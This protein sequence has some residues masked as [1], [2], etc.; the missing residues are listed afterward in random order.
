MM[1][2]DWKNGLKKVNWKKGLQTAGGV[3]R[4]VGGAFKDAKLENPI[5]SVGV[6]LFV[7]IFCGILVCVVTLGW[8]SYSQSRTIIKTKVADSNSQTAEQIAGRLN[9][10]LTSYEQKTMEFLSDTSFM[11]TL[12]KAVSPNV[13]EFER[14][15]AQRDVSEK[16]S[17]IIFADKNINGVYLLPSQ[18]N[19]TLQPIGTASSGSMPD[20]SVIKDMPFMKQMLDAQGKA[21]WAPT[22]EKGL[23]GS[24]PTP[25]IAVGRALVNLSNGSNQY[26]IVIELN[27]TFLKDLVDQFRTGDGSTSR[28][29]APDGTIVYSSIAKENGTK[30][31]NPLPK[32]GQGITVKEN[33]KDMLS[34]GGMI[35]L[36]QWELVGNVPV[37]ELVRDAR[38]ISGL[39]WIMSGVSALI[40]VGIGL[41]VMRQVGRPLVQLRAL[42]NE[43]ERGNLTVR[44]T[45]RKKDEIGQVADSFNRMME[46]ITVLVRQT[47]QSAKD[48]LDT[49]STLSEASRKT[50]TS[51]K[52]IAVATEEIA[53]G[54]TN[55]A[56][57]S[58][59][60]TEIT[61]RIGERVQSVIQSNEEMGHAAEIVQEA[62]RKGT[63]YM[64]GL[65]EKTG[66]TE[67]MT[68]SMVEKVDQLK[69]S[70]RSIRK[71]LDVLGNITKQT[72]IL[73]LNATIEAAR[74]GAAGKGFMVVADEI[75]KLADQ[76]RDSIGIVG[77]I[78][79]RIQR[80]I[81]E[82]VSV[83]SAAYPLFQ[84]QILSVREATQI[85][86]DVQNHMAGFVQ[87]L[88]SATEAVKHLEEAQSTLSLAMTNVS[89]VAQ[90]SS[91][92]SEEVASLS[93]EQLSVSE[94]LVQ[95][96]NRLET[97]SAQLRESLS[98]FTVS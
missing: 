35:D 22:M 20:M 61:S 67:E 50:A 73:S 37:S 69:E 79:E 63:D 87:R 17:S 54:A 94:G 13:E 5:R 18:E 58:E 83:L 1:K 96:S 36:N 26:V 3:T 57:E 95:L 52:E 7:L 72:N 77:E 11:D 41:L 30:Y 38:S 56:M 39:T 2:S 84:E 40:A 47:G 24:A 71:I 98:K 85:F 9:L 75:R 12:S 46:Q 44:S 59:R 4:Q 14:F 33:G 66:Q 15:T 62:G 10:M 97:V 8:F 51:A 86:H 53:S 16:F 64:A 32:T 28:I 91:A 34:V 70:T 68:R 88:E 31:P 23:S 45:I 42:M 29:V 21:V 74:A 49:A 93:N 76:S 6:Q 90:Q 27:Y 55:L 60:G 80:E 82:T 92:T 78:V 89:A 43:G 48:V 19:G 81:D 25:T 65:I